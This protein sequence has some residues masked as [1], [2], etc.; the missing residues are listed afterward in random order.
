MFKSIALALIFIFSTSGFANLLE[1]FIYQVNKV[2]VNQEVFQKEGFWKDH[3]QAA[4]WNRLATLQIEGNSFCLLFRHLPERQKK[5]EAMMLVKKM[6]N[7]ECLE[8][9]ES[10]LWQAMDIDQTKIEWGESEFY[11]SYLES[12][13]YRLYR[14]KWLSQI[15]QADGLTFKA[16][17]KSPEAA[18]YSSPCLQLD[19]KCQPL[20][21]SSCDSCRDGIVGF[22]VEKNCAGQSLYCR[23]DKNCGASEQEACQLT[24]ETSTGC[25]DRKAHYFCQANLN[26]VCEKG[27]MVCY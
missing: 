19:K 20:K 25:E 3:L 17:V 9:I 10:P 1:P 12:Q 7:R 21:A 6:A 22:Y 4:F 13:Q 14:L 15:F 16:K 5:K 23:R 26:M 27:R 24:R 18:D 8:E 2:E 11:L